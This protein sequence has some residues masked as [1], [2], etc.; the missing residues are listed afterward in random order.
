MQAESAILSQAS[1]LESRVTNPLARYCVVRTAV[2]ITVFLEKGERMTRRHGR[3][4][5]HA[6]VFIVHGPGIETLP[7]PGGDFWRQ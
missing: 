1:P 3:S 4:R 5:E 6:E 2:V 7:T